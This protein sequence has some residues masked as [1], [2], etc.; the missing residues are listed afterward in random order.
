MSKVKRLIA[1]TLC[2]AA[3][4]GMASHA[5]AALVT[6]DGS[7]FD[8]VYDDSLLG[9]YGTPTIVGDTVQ[10]FPSGSPAFTAQVN[11]SNAGDQ[12]NSTLAIRVIA[13][14]LYQITGA[15]VNEGGDYFFSGSGT[16][17]VTVTGQLRLADANVSVPDV[18]TDSI[19]SPTTF[20]GNTFPDTTSRNWTANAS[21]TLDAPIQAAN[22][23][24]QNILGAFANGAAPLQTAFIE[25]NNVFL[26]VGVAPVPEPG[27]WAMVG[28]GLGMIAFSI[29]RQMR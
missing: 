17:G 1:S 22:I 19:V 13:D 29:R 16:S 5:S 18:L 15:T 25:K 2:A 9:L 26:T 27:T 12:I 8:I 24:V 11:N 14:P 21:L 4:W 6:L 7:F 20:T 23:S 3:T 28:L 10:W